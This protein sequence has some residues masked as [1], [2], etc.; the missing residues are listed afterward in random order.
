MSQI[1]PDP[2]R[3][4]GLALVDPTGEKVGRVAEVYLNSTD[5]RPAWLVVGGGR[6]GMRK[7]WLPVT[8]IRLIGSELH[9]PF[10]SEQIREAPSAEPGSSLDPEREVAL[11]EHYRI[12]STVGQ[13]AHAERPLA[14]TAEPGS[15]DDAMTRS[16]EQVLLRRVVRPA[17]H[18]RLVKHVVV[19]ERQLTVRVRREELRVERMP[20]GPGDGAADERIGELREA[21]EIAGEIVLYEER[22]VVGTTVVPRER[23]RLVKSTVTEDRTIRADVAKEQIEVEKEEP[24]TD[25]YNHAK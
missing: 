13:F 9:T 16:E 15:E 19:E 14:A 18:V 5:D 20:Y 17:E 6:F 25:E 21:E 3:W 10:R 11:Y 23:V 4:Q 7:M 1:A 12:P 2:H 24:P 8:G 22:P